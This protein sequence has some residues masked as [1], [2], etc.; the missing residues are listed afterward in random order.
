MATC[1]NRLS[2]V[3]AGV[4]QLKPAAQHFPKH[5][6]NTASLSRQLPRDPPPAM[7]EK[8]QD[9]RAKYC[10]GSFSSHQEFYSQLW[11]V[12]TNLRHIPPGFLVCK[13]N[14]DAA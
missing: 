4:E 2:W 5:P 11:M 9:A 12:Q 7:P 13:T 3:R 6:C 1:E 10:L 14:E 8:Q